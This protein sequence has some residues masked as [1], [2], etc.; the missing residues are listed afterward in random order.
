[1]GYT[2]DMIYG[3]KNNQNITYWIKKFNLINYT[4]FLD[5]KKKTFESWNKNK[6]LTVDEFF[7]MEEMNEEEFCNFLFDEDYFEYEI[8]KIVSDFVKNNK[9][10]TVF[11]DYEDSDFSVGVVVKDYDTFNQKEN[12]L[13]MLHIL[14]DMI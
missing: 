10:S 14:L 8:K 4:E 13:E 7:N 1:M 5:N 6:D 12:V 9:I 2:Q 3:I 11:M